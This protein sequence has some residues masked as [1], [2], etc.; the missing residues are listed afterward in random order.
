MMRLWLTM[1]FLFAGG[2]AA[3]GEGE[4]KEPAEAAN[5]AKSIEQL[6]ILIPALEAAQIELKEMEQRLAAAATEAE[7]AAVGKEVFEQ[8]QRVDQ[9]RENFLTIAT[10][11]EEDRYQNRDGDQASWEQNLE[12]I[13]AP[14]SRSVREVT[15]DAREVEQLRNDLK[16]WN[17]RV[18]L[19]E[20]AT[21]R[22][23]DLLSKTEN[24]SIRQE[25]AS[26]R[27]LWDRRLTE[28]KSQA[29]VLSEQTRE[30]KEDRP[31]TWE[32]VS[33]FIAE[34]WRSR[35]L[36]LL[37]ALVSAIL[38]FIVARRGYRF[39]RSF[40][41]FH[42]RGGHNL[43]AR[44]LDLAWAGVA[45]LL[46]LGTAVLIFYLRG[47][48]LLL[49]LSILFILGILWAS[50]RAVPPYLE[51][52]RLI[53]NLGPVR[54]GERMV[55]EGIAWRVDRLNFYCEFSNPALA[56]A[57]LRL[58]VRDVMPLHSRPVLPKEPWF[59]TH[60]DDW[61][62]LADDTFGK[63]IQQSQEQV[64]VLRLGGSLKTYPTAEFFGQIP[65]NLSRGFRI[66][67]TFGIDYQHQAICTT[68]VPE[69][70]RI[71]IEKALIERVDRGHL[72]SLKVEFS[73][74]GA[75]S[76]DYA[77]LAD[78][79]GEVASR[80]NVLQRLIQKTCVDVCNKHGWVIPFT[81]VTVHQASV[82]ASAPDEPVDEIAEA[83]AP[84]LP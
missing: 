22:L 26:A 46:A 41:P 20:E 11:V 27:K 48:W 71:S 5:L 2:F 43:A 44:V 51:Q 50:K 64:V 80:Y 33:Q 3:V 1:L 45:G 9:L 13:I 30:R 58:P 35:G 38:V 61:I 62:R 6:K 24:P 79:D 81:Q 63:V 73:S 37:L 83:E 49:A 17:E 75:S 65:E 23:E 69:I 68:K 53:L 78:F 16:D 42:R 39:V 25:L 36:N 14:I 70:F 57:V 74:A 67:S 34:F 32:S 72:R 12:D 60:Q 40:S 77:V 10:G 66:N 4:S 55:Y 19:A 54:Q 21:K 31:S 59:P 15:A 7:K 82:A 76:L 56:G 84:G 8:R 52:L 29:A 18:K 47:D 28:A